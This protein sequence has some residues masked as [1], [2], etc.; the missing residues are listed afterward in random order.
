MARAAPW[1]LKYPGEKFA[2]AIS[3]NS[4]RWWC[5]RLPR[6]M[7]TLHGH[8]RTPQVRP[9]LTPTSSPQRRP[10]HSRIAPHS[11]VIARRRLRRWKRRR[12]RTPLHLVGIARS[13]VE[14]RIPTST[15]R[16]HHAWC[17]YWEGG[18]R[19]RWPL[20]PTTQGLHGTRELE[21]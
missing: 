13:G 19:S 11:V 8:T 10:A 4:A 1:R 14:Q 17:F 6:S 21:A 9:K 3:Q 15:A 7:A 16:L 20:W 2:R 18:R 5:S 12:P